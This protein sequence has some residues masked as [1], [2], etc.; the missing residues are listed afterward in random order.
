MNNVTLLLLVVVVGAMLVRGMFRPGGILEFPFLAAATMAGWFI[1]QAYLLMDDPALPE[2]GFDAT[3]GMAA[4]SMLA[5]LLGDRYSSRVSVADTSQFDEWRLLIGAAWLSGIGAVAF[6]ALAGTSAEQADGGM[7]RP[8][9]RQFIFS[10]L[11]HSIL[12]LLWQ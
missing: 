6:A 4:L 12:D 2:F 1:P 10:S 9:L 11:P 3:M 5:I 7:T 8:G